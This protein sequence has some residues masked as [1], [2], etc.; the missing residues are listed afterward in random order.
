MIIH[1]R[2]LIRV[3]RRNAQDGYGLRELGVVDLFYS[4]TSQIAFWV[5]FLVY[6]YVRGFD[7]RIDGSKT[8]G[9]RAR[10]DWVVTRQTYIEQERESPR[11]RDDADIAYMDA[12]A[13]I[14]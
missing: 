10:V 2:R 8:V 9:K 14:G 7:R 4:F 12:F 3:N 6:A 5:E 1:C 13:S 11:R